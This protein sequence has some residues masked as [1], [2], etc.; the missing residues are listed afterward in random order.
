[1]V[2][3]PALSALGASI[4]TTRAI[5]LKPDWSEFPVIWAC[6]IARSGTMKSPAHDAALRPMRDAQDQRFREHEAARAEYESALERYKGEAAER[7]RGSIPRPAP[8]KPDAPVCVRYLVSDATVEALAPIL[9][10]NPRGL[11]LARDEL[12]GWVKSFNQYKSR[13][14]ADAQNWL[15]LW[16]AGTLTVDRKTGDARMIHVRRAAASVCGTIQPGVFVDA[17]TGEHFES[18]LAARLLIAHPPES[19][20][21]WSTRSAGSATKKAYDDTMSALL[22]LEHVAGEHGPDPV[23]LCLSRDAESGWGEWYDAHARRIAEAGSDS[24]AAAL[25][26]L[27]AYAARF[28]LIFTL[29]ESASA[30]EVGVDAMRRG[31]ALA[32]WFAAEALRVYGLLAEDDESRDLR[33]LCEWIERR[34]GTVTV[35]ELTRGMRRFRGTPDEARAALDGLVNGGIARRLDDAPGPRGGRPAERYELLSCQL[36]PTL[37]AGSGGLV[38]STPDADPDCASV[39]D[40]GTEVVEI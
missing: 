25:A 1:M 8:M 21:R 22:G 35:T 12:A 26:K 16:R 20:K 23:K 19:I 10:G 9:A 37:G 5:R 39:D 36:N 38:D 24:E 2:A 13:G 3:L 30:R 15:E 17:M 4:G 31:C 33:A 11:L 6:V 14:G 7:R 32:D 18:G 29:V 27:E 34:G 40:A 28:A